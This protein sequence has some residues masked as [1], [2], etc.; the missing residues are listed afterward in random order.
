MTVAV[1]MPGKRS[2]GASSQAA[3][4]C[5]LGKNPSASIADFA[6]TGLDS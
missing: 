4:N 5:Y 3:I 6:V 2:C 1:L